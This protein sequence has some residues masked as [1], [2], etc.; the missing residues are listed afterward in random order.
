MLRAMRSMI[1]V[2]LLAG[3]G[4]G[5]D[6]PGPPPAPEAPAPEAPPP[7]ATTVESSEPEAEA[8]TPPSAQPAPLTPEQRREVRA[9]VRAGRRAASE[10]MTAA[11]LRHF[12]RALAIAPTNARVQCEA[13]FVALSS[14]APEDRA[15]ARRHLEAG[16]ARFGRG[17]PPEALRVPV[18]MCLYNRGLYAE[19]TGALDEAEAYYERS[20]ALRDNRTVREHLAAART[21]R[22][23]PTDIEPAASL[24]ALIA[25]W[26]RESAADDDDEDYD[27]S[28]SLIHRFAPDGD[29]PEV[30]MIE[31]YADS[32]MSWGSDVSFVFAI[33]DAGGYRVHR[34]YDGTT[35]RNDAETEIEA[36][37]ATLVAPGWLRVDYRGRYTAGFTEELAPPDPE[38][39]DE[40]DAVDCW[41]DE[42]STYENAQSLLCHLGEVLRCGLLLTRVHEASSFDVQCEGETIPAWAREAEAE[43]RDSNDYT[44]TLETDPARGL[45]LHLASGEVPADRSGPPLDTWVSF[46]SVVSA[47]GS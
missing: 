22:A 41:G 28:Y 32:G 12:D 25:R 4:G 45:S 47:A 15:Y 40:A 17:T 3:C 24:D 23:V 34:H 46:E 20:L 36:T 16:L 29:R 2:I 39:V 5:T 9:A 10:R 19:R 14:D 27:T 26:N 31:E 35:S 42:S 30:A 7:E 44:L 11:A 6:A 8:T 18:A 21:G 38:N 33:R 1:A 13:G 37:Q 43:P